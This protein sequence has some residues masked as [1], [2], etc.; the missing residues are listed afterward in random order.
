ME[1]SCTESDLNSGGLA[2]EVSE[3]RKFSVLPRDG[4]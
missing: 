2:Q 4:F 1:G 3:E